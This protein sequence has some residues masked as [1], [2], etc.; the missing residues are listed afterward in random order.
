VSAA[1]AAMVNSVL[2]GITAPAWAV[3]RW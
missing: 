1:I 2:T 3:D